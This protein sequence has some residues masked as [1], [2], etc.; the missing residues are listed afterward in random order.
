MADSKHATV[1]ATISGVDKQARAW[2][3]QRVGSKAFECFENGSGKRLQDIEFSE[4]MMPVIIA[5]MSGSK[6]IVRFP[7]KG[8][9]VARPYELDLS[10]MVYE[11]TEEN[12]IKKYSLRPA[13]DLLVARDAN[14][15]RVKSKENS[16]LFDV[17]EGQ[18]ATLVLKGTFLEFVAYTEP[19]PRA[20]STPP[21]VQ[22]TKAEKEEVLETNLRSEHW[23]VVN[24]TPS[25]LMP[26]Q[27]N[28]VVAAHERAVEKVPGPNF[29]TS[30]VR[31]R[32]QANA[33]L[34]KDPLVQESEPSQP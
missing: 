33:S 21:S 12:H 18:Q 13:P 4:E 11:R 19:R 2:L 27:W 34:A 6:K 10:T 28:E 31:T 24:G 16:F 29:C 5:Y 23:E 1:N 3:K 7:I 20:Q 26:L 17:G 22:A 9:K 14:S 30:P 32:W 25:G 8:K 15:K